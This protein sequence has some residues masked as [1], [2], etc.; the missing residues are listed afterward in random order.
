[1]AI[2]QLHLNHHFQWLQE[3]ALRTFY[4]S[5]VLS[6]PQPKAV[7]GAMANSI[8]QKTSGALATPTVNSIND[9][10]INEVV[11]SPYPTLDL[12]SQS[13]NKPPD[14]AAMLAS[15]DDVA[16]NFIPPL[17]HSFEIDEFVRRISSGTNTDESGH[18]N[19][20]QAPKAVEALI[21]EISS[22]CPKFERTSS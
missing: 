8:L 9:D 22:H 2:P 3:K 20:S 17:I 14:V 7:K 15:E 6:R 12:A 18:N 1:V 4:N 10:A 11:C 16:I 21:Y 19:K 5:G 13:K